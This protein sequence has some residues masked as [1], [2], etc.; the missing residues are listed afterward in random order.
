MTEFKHTPGPWAQE[1][2]SN[3]VWYRVAAKA[4]KQ[5]GGG[6]SICTVRPAYGTGE[7]LGEA[8]ANAHL[9]AAA[10]EMARLLDTLTSEQSS[11]Q[12]VGAAYAAARALLSRLKGDGA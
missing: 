12:Q 7:A 2:S 10:P 4:P 1:D 11:A 6:R 3:T 5:H 8:K 9:I